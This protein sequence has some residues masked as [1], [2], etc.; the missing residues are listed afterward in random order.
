MDPILAL[1]YIAI[2][3]LVGILCKFIAKELKLPYSL[4]L[5][6]LGMLFG[7]IF[8]SG[9]PLL[10]IDNN[11]ILGIG[12][13]ALVMLVFDSASRIRVKE[14]AL[15]ALPS[16]K[17]I[18]LFVLLS[19]LVVSFFTAEMF[20][21]SMTLSAVIYSL[22]LS[23]MVVETDLG[24]VL[25]IFKDFAKDRAKHVLNFLETEANLNTAFVIVLPFVILGLFNNINFSSQNAALSLLHNLPDFLYGILV[26]L[27]VGIVVGLIM[28]RLMRDWYD[29]Q[30]TP[31]ALVA[32]ALVAY[33]FSLL[34]GGNGII[35]VAVMGFIFGNTFVSG[36]EQLSEFSQMFSAAV[37]I[38]VFVMLGLVV[39]LPIS[40][41]YVLMTLLLF[42]V[43]LAVRTLAVFISL[44][45]DKEFS[46]YEKMF[47]GLNMPKGIAIASVVLVLATYG[48]PALSVV[49]QLAVMMMIYSIV[50]SF[51]LDFYAKP[52]LTDAKVSAPSHHGINVL[53]ASGASVEH[54]TSVRKAGK[55]RPA[56]AKSKARPAKPRK[57]AAKRKPAKAKKASGAA[58]KKAKKT[59]KKKA[60]RKK[61]K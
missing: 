52:F 58:G 32:A 50:L 16:I 60:S 36:K 54:K 53:D 12:T 51:I 48:V 21:Y 2:V 3:L 37:E 27:G 33:A 1:A 10:R 61:K 9:N 34:L 40:F 39:R 31:V 7:T 18:N 13:L 41:S 20:Y 5:I 8:F 35:A 17:F 38:L 6:L 25:L 24:S 14:N 4:I 22:F 45:D 57:K 47:I 46:D 43:V 42:V 23:V 26:A 30:F 59:A 44:K 19:V 29:E 49:L 55:K 28:L 56:K 11:L 15:E